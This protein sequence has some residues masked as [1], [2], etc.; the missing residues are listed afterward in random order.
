MPGM[1][2]PAAAFRGAAE[3]SLAVFQRV[4]PAIRLLREE[5]GLSSARLAVL[6][7]TGKSQ[8]CKYENGKELP[9]LESLARLLD[10]LDVEPLILFYW[11]GRLS[12]GVLEED[13]EEELLRAEAR[14]SPG[15]Q[16]FENLFDAALA[17][18][19]AYIVARL[20]NEETRR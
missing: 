20:R 12:R 4:G 8:L 15:S 13:I 11:A 5:R 10:A 2:D 1:S 17:A 19:K 7:S 18:H 6:S 9:K 16:P 3:G 14:R